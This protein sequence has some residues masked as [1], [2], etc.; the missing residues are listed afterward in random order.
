MEHNNDEE[1]RG[2][3]RKI[4]MRRRLAK[5]EEHKEEKEGEKEHCPYHALSGLGKTGINGQRERHEP[6]CAVS[7]LGIITL[8]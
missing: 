1:E 2:K 8:N 5:E 4:R 6:A 7:Q 3:E